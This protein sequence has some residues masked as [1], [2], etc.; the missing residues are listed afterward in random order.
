MATIKEQVFAC[1]PV[2]SDG[3]ATRLSYA[4]LRK[5]RVTEGHGWKESYEIENRSGEKI[6]LDSDAFRALCLIIGSFDPE[7]KT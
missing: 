6:T 1:A 5:V 7:V 3:K 4:T 2:L